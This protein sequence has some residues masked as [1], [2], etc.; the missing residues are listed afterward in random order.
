MKRSIAMLAAVAA[1]FLG[2]CS[3]VLSK[4]KA[5]EM[6]DSITKTG[7]ELASKLEGIKDVDAAK[8]AKSSIET[9]ATT[10]SG[11]TGK[12]TAIKSILG[13]QAGSLT[14]IVDKVKAAAGKLMENASIKE[15][16][17]SALS[18]LTK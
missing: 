15:V 6:F 14:G 5:Q 4:D 3:E 7:T 11:L 9:M 2:G 8:A 16:L 10:F 13:D 18:K 1:L 12:L 17:G